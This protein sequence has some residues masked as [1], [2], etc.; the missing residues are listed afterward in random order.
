MWE[1]S[2]NGVMVGSM[3]DAFRHPH[4]DVESSAKIFKRR[5]YHIAA[6]W[7]IDFHM[8]E[9]LGMCSGSY[10]VGV[11]PDYSHDSESFLHRTPG[12]MRVPS[13]PSVLKKLGFRRR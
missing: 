3:E 9:D 7:G 11:P 8:Q 13:G 2:D 10:G 6:H 5:M 12:S 4:R 1:S